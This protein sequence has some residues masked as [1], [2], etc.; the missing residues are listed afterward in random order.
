[1]PSFSSIIFTSYFEEAEAYVLLEDIIEYIPEG[2]QR[3]SFTALPEVK[4]IN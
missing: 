3:A 1:V 2:E 4:T